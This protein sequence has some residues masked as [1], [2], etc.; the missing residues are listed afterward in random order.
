MPC[1]SE[2]YCD[3]SIRVSRIIDAIELGSRKTI[4][5]FKGAKPLHNLFD[6]GTA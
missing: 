6:R 5:N 2:E 4:D 1:S 3:C